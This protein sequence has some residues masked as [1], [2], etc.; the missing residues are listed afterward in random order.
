MA[1]ICFGPPPLPPNKK[2]LLNNNNH[3]LRKPL[4]STYHSF[5]DPSEEITFT[6]HQDE[7][8][9]IGLKLATATLELDTPHYDTANIRKT[10]KLCHSNSL[11][12]EKK[13]DVKLSLYRSQSDGNLN[14]KNFIVAPVTLNKC[15]K[16]LSGSWKNL[17][18]RKY[19]RY[20]QRLLLSI[21]DGVHG[22][23]VINRYYI[24]N[25]YDTILS[26]YYNSYYTHTNAKKHPTNTKLVNT[27]KFIIMKQYYRNIV[28]DSSMIIKLKEFFKSDDKYRNSII[29]PPC[30]RFNNG[31]K[32]E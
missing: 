12:R 7:L 11:R 3:R 13:T 23:F 29:A 8:K 16:V 21:M 22:N 17:L 32:F 15:M 28:E 27:F 30:I 9:A 10:R 19:T 25:Y 2:S 14:K 18:Q 1:A 4:S 26:N 6:S 20:P 31:A 5:R 24:L